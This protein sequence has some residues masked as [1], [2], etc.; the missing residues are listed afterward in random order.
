[1]AG[2][3]NGVVGE[4]SGGDLC[5]CVVREGTGVGGDSVV[6]VVVG[7]EGKTTGGDIS[8][9]SLISVGD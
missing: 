2:V 4:E 1:M 9:E 5:V 8:R 6:E 3:H 7:K